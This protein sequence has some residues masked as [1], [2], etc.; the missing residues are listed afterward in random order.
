MKIHSG[1]H[2]RGGHYKS[3]L[4]RV[5][6]KNSADRYSVVFF[7]DSNLDYKLRRLDRIGKLTD[8][9][10]ALAV[11]EHMQERNTTSYGAAKK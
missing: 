4:H 11:E 9:G 8:E 1:C 10:E 5:L 3:S 7:F 2:S 6:N